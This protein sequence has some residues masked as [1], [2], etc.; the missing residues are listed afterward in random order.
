MWPKL[1]P[2]PSHDF[3]A[4]AGS[5]KINERG[6]RFSGGGKAGRRIVLPVH[7]EVR[8]MIGTKAICVVVAL[9]G[10][11]AFGQS[12]APKFEVASVKRVN[13]GGPPGDIPRN[14][15]TSPG[16]FAMRNVPLRMAI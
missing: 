16:H 4:D 3:T 1:R 11:T 9:A 6:V 10:W 5:A 7:Q 14:M 8:N 2:R 15:D 13:G 12:P